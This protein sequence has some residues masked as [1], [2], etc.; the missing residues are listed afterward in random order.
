MPLN[1]QLFRIVCLI[2][3]AMS[4]YYFF[5]SMTSLFEQ[6]GLLH[7]F[8]LICF[9]LVATFAL[10]AFTLINSNYPNKPVAGKQKSWFNWLFLL[11]FLVL[12]FLFSIFFSTLRDYKHLRTL[13]PD[14]LIPS[15]WKWVL[16]TTALILIFQF[17]ILFGMYSLRRLLF[18][19]AYKIKQFEFEEKE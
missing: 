10:F 17:I 6:G 4:I 3:S 8:S 9:G 13:V 5:T 1:W 7:F 18:I 15:A 19:N 12:A 2:Q 11:D 16:G 14:S